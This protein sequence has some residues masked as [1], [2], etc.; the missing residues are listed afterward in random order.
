MN[1]KNIAANGFNLLYGCLRAIGFHLSN[2][3]VDLIIDHLLK[4]SYEKHGLY[5]GKS[6]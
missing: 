4:R 3:V 1:S 2:L 5:S 6:A